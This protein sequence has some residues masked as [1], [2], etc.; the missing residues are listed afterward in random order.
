MTRRCMV[1]KRERIVNVNCKNFMRC[2]KW[3]KTGPKKSSDVIISHNKFS[4]NLTK[5][6]P[7]CVI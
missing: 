1:Q 3:F 5:I 6:W 4:Q 7:T 2:V